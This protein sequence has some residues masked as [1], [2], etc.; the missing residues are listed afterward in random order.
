M[1]GSSTAAWRSRSRSGWTPCRTADGQGLRLAARGAAQGARGLGRV[2]STVRGRAPVVRGLR[3]RGARGVPAVRWRDA[4]P[5]PVLLGAVQ[6]DVHRGV[7]VVRKAASL[8]RA[9]RHEDPARLT[10][11]PPSNTCRLLAR[12]HAAP[13][14]TLA[15][16]KANQPCCGRVRPLA[17]CSRPRSSTAL[18]EGALVLDLGEADDGHGV[19]RRDLAVVELAQEGRHVLGAADLGIVVLDLARGQL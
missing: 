5:L 17:W 2:L 11:A 8:P 9:L 14:S 7:R 10:C 16:S 13:E 6:L 15:L 3:G 19:V 18:L 1:R 12:D 4:T